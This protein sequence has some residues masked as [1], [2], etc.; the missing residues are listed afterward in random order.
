[1][2]VRNV[3]A[4]FGVAVWLLSPPARSALVHAP[5]PLPLANL[6]VLIAEDEGLIALNLESMLAD[7]GCEVVGPV[8]DVDD[9]LVAARRMRLHGALLDVNLR[10]RQVFGVLPEL[11]ALRVPIVLTSGYD[12]ATLFPLA[13]RSL[14]RLAKPFDERAL[15]RACLD[16]MLAHAA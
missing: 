11:M 10:G 1:M 15:R 7:L 9:I 4:F 6:N 14:P 2:P 5:A 16:T 12:D 13:F 3:C 8:A